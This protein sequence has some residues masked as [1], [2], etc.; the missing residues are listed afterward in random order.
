MAIW[1]ENFWAADF[2]AE[3]FWNEVESGEVSLDI[4]VWPDIPIRQFRIDL[5][6]DKTLTESLFTRTRQVLSMTAGTADRWEG[7][8][9]TPMLFPA[10]VRT[11]MNFLVDVGMYGQFLLPHPDYDGP[12]AGTTSGRVLGSGQTGRQLIVD[13]LPVSAA[14][15]LEGDW[16]QVNS[17]FK[18]LTANATTNGSGQVTLNF[19]PPLRVSPIDNDEVIFDEPVLL[20][21]LTS[22]PGEETDSLRMMSFTISFQEALVGE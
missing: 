22:M 1:A 19:K 17:E 14:V 16:F 20:A 9:T 6:E 7:L 15:A 18:R 10:D 4:P 2:W 8:L 3:D 5:N 13:D 21:E 11:V 12:S